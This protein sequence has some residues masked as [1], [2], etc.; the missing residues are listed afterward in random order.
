MNKNK[1]QKTLPPLKPALAG[2]YIQLKG[3]VKA[4]SFLFEDDSGLK[5][6]NHVEIAR[7]QKNVPK[8]FIFKTLICL[9]FIIFTGC[10]APQKPKTSQPVYQAS[11]LLAGLRVFR[12]DPA[13]YR[14]V[15]A[16]MQRG[17]E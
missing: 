3:F 2:W 7:D 15:E 9:I 16:A 12:D 14:A 8:G 10:A 13:L 17:Q 4:G 1:N 6:I 5:Q 11:D